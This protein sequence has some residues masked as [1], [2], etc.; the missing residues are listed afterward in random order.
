MGTETQSE[1]IHLSG[2]KHNCPTQM[3][4][5]RLE[6]T[7]RFISS[8]LSFTLQHEVAEQGGPQGPFLHPISTRTGGDLA[9]SYN[10]LR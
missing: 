8:S 6:D 3:G 10:L 7:V 2:P 1:F 4:V 5:V 9:Y